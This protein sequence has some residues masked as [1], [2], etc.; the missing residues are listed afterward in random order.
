MAVDSPNHLFVIQHQPPGSQQSRRKEVQIS[1]NHPVVFIGPNQIGGGFIAQ[2]L[3]H[4]HQQR[5]NQPCGKSDVV[6][7][8]TLMNPQTIGCQRRQ[9]KSYDGAKYNRRNQLAQ[10]V[11]RYQR[12]LCN[13]RG[14]GG[15]VQRDVDILGKAFS[16]LFG[17]QIDAQNDGPDI[18]DVFSKH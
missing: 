5:T 12:H 10:K 3:H 18:G 8:I 15:A 13:H 1:H 7:V 6:E 16:L 17:K 2:R 14:Q 11:I 9:Q 4:R